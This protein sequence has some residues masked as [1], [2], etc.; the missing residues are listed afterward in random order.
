MGPD[1]R[2]I[3]PIRADATGAEIA[4]EIGKLMS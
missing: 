1:G 2:F 3:A 4:A